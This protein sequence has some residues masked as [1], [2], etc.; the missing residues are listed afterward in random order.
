MTSASADAA[1]AAAFSYETAA[2]PS[3]VSTAS[4][5]RPPALLLYGHVEKTGGTSVRD[6]LQRRA[7]AG[8][9]DLF[10]PYMFSACFMFTRFAAAVGA[11]TAEIARCGGRSRFASMFDLKGPPNGGV[12][13]ASR[14]ASSV[15]WRTARI[16]VE[17]HGDP[18]MGTFVGRVLPNLAALRWR[19]AD[20]GGTVLS[21]VALREPIA[22]LRS[23]FRMWPPCSRP[24]ISGAGTR[25]GSADAKCG[26]LAVSF[27]DFAQMA[28]GAQAGRLA[29][30]GAPRRTAPPQ[31]Q[32][33]RAAD[34][35][36]RGGESRGG[37]DVG[38][39]ASGGRGRPRG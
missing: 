21:M 4:Q 15:D 9:L 33:A 6:W 25:N 37:R 12:V 16:A 38:A 35:S 7:R 39:R 24:L 8:D 5:R 28:E 27:A 17:F 10:V 32:A 19:Y 29:L 3:T 1:N 11:T 30:V 20:R 26:P 34:A 31:Q 2:L 14:N 36:E 18:T 22:H 23:S 13:G